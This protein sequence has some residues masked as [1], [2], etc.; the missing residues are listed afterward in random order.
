M[1][2][3]AR[4]ILGAGGKIPLGPSA[5]LPL[6]LTVLLVTISQSNC[7]LLVTELAH[8]QHRASMTAMY[9]ANW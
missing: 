9:N 6:L 8:T 5:P 2:V 1:F 3:I 4:I 7:P